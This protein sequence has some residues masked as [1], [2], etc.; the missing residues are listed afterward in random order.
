M[1]V[2]P[3]GSHKRRSLVPAMWSA[4]SDFETSI[5]EDLLAKLTSVSQTSP[6]FMICC[7]EGLLQLLN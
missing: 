6:Q 4:F 1:F 2:L 7:N 3:E 5:K